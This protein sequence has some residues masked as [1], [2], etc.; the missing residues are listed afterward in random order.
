MP[1]TSLVIDHTTRAYLTDHDICAEANIS[2]ELIRRFSFNV[3]KRLL[4]YIR[5]SQINALEMMR[6]LK[7][8]P[9]IKY[10][11]FLEEEKYFSQVTRARVMCV[12]QDG[13]WTSFR[14]VRKICSI[15]RTFTIE[16]A[17]IANSNTIYESVEEYEIEDCKWK[18]GLKSFLKPSQKKQSFSKSEEV[19]LPQSQDPRNSSYEMYLKCTGLK[20]R[21]C[22]VECCFKMISPTADHPTLALPSGQ[23]SQPVTFASDSHVLFGTFY[24]SIPGV[25]NS[26]NGVRTFQVV[27]NSFDCSL[28]TH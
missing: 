14:A 5:I 27:F 8:R 12:Q 25:Y 10:R 18:I 4:S 19:I 21:Q 15:V 24:W 23:I 6:L 7:A 26:I 28:N 3:L 1:S 9:Y 20:D 17:V 13:L 2:A 16:G 22:T 11:E